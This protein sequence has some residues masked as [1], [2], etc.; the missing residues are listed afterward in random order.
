MVIEYLLSICTGVVFCNKKVSS[1]WQQ[2]RRKLGGA[3]T[4]HPDQG[5]PEYL[6]I[7]HGFEGDF[8]GDE[9][10]MVDE[11]EWMSASY[12]ERHGPVKKT[13]EEAADTGVP[14]VLPPILAVILEPFADASFIDWERFEAPFLFSHWPVPEGLHAR[15]ALEQE[16]AHDRAKT[17]AKDKKRQEQPETKGGLS[18]TTTTGA[19]GSGL[20]SKG[21]GV[22]PMSEEDNVIDELSLDARKTANNA[23]SPVIPKPV[24]VA[25]TEPSE[26]GSVRSDRVEVEEAAD[27]LLRFHGSSSQPTVAR[28]GATRTEL[29]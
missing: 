17:N 5:S 10:P 23:S 18:S 4:S 22:K 7:T 27:L 16:A 24:R 3:T 26:H 14:L 6:S 25:S 8:P 20:L 28:A 11:L 29:C 15:W 12:K 21:D 1:H 9:N 13:K 2:V 19:P